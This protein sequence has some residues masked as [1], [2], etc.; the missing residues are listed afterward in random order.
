MVFRAA[1]AIITPGSHMAD[2]A[3]MWPGSPDWPSSQRTHLLPMSAAHVLNNCNDKLATAKLGP[4]SI[5][6]GSEGGRGGQ[7]PRSTRPCALAIA[8]PRRLK[9]RPGQRFRLEVESSDT[10]PSSP[11]QPRSRLEADDRADK[12]KTSESPGALACQSGSRRLSGASVC[13]TENRPDG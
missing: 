11:L 2:M 4:N 1:P 6:P 5:E 10:F 8:F 13:V 9:F 12:K 3:P 7:P